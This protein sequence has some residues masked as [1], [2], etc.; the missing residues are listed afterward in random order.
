MDLKSMKLLNIENS[1]GQFSLGQMS[2]HQT[3][4]LIKITWYEESVTGFVTKDDTSKTTLG[5]LIPCKFKLPNFFAKSL[6][7]PL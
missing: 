6:N 3:E 5:N 1:I 2:G 4:I 7:K